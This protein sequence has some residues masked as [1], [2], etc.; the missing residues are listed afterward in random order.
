MDGSR[1]DAM[2][3][4]LDL[5]R[6]RP[7]ARRQILRALSTAPL[8]GGL[9][10]LLGTAEAGPNQRHKGNGHSGPGAESNSKKKRKKR[11]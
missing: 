3:K 5:A 11:K 6:S 4:R 7:G 10:T 8:I 2:T 1:F 9:S